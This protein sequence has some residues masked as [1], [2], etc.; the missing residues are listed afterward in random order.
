LKTLQQFREVFGEE[1]QVSCRR[2]I[3]KVHEES[4]RGTLVE[5]IAH[6][7]EREPKG[8]FVIVVEGRRT[9]DEKRKTKGES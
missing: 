5:V 4:V 2:E 1:R 9:K 6:F 7:Q 8:E 3:S